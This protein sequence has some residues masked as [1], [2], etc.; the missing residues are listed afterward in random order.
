MKTAL[1]TGITGQTGSYM[2]EL[3]LEKGYKVYG[4]K[5]RSSTSNLHRVEHIKDENF[6]VIH[7]ELTD[8]SSI[9]KL[10]G[11]YQPDELYNFAAQSFVGS[12]FDEPAH[13]FQVDTI[14]V[15]NCLEA[16]RNYSHKTKFYNAGSS[17]EFGDN[18]DGHLVKYQN[19]NTRLSP[20][21]PYGCA[22]VCARHLVETYRK[23]YGLFACQNWLFNH[24]SPRRGEE[25]VTRKITRYIG[26]LNYWLKNVIKNDT[27]SFN[28]KKYIFTIT[29]I[30]TKIAL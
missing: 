19:E 5:R 9:N 27:L 6:S 22:K 17:E 26:V 10:V 1:V 13:T 7:G 8:P 20:V 29:Q 28:D 21:S 2:V 4:M 23:S 16:I 25:F 14:G 30:F 24:E 18:Y 11:D 15:L 12:S 3:L